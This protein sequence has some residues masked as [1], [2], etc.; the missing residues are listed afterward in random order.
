MKREKSFLGIEI[1]S[2]NSSINSGGENSREVYTTK[3]TTSF[4]ENSFLSMFLI[5]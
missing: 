1:R 3:Q 4:F 5:K 2:F